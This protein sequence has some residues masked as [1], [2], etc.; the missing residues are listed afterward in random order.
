VK[1]GEIGPVGQA[2]I[3]RAEGSSLSMV[4]VGDYREMRAARKL[5]ARGVFAYLGYFDTPGCQSRLFVLRKA[6]EEAMTEE[7]S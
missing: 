2:L 6:I 7:K 4:Y 3:E 5:A 1:V